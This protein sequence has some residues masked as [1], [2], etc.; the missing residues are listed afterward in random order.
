MTVEVAENLSMVVRYNG[1]TIHF[2]GTEQYSQLSGAMTMFNGNAQTLLHSIS[3]DLNP[4]ISPEVAFAEL[5]YKLD[6]NTDEIAASGNLYK[7][8]SEP[9]VIEQPP[10]PSAWDSWLVGTWQHYSG[11]Q[12][13]IDDDKRLFY[14]DANQVSFEL[15]VE[16]DPDGQSVGGSS[17]SDST[18]YFLDAEVFS[19]I[20]SG[21][22][23]DIIVANVNLNGSMII[24]GGFF[25]RVSE[26]PPEPNPE[27]DW[28]GIWQGS[29]GASIDIDMDTFKMV[30]TAPNTTISYD[31]VTYYDVGDGREGLVTAATEV[32]INGQSEQVTDD[33]MLWPA[34]VDA[35][36]IFVELSLYG[37]SE[38]FIR[39]G[40]EPT[41]GGENAVQFE[42]V[43]IWLRD[44]A[45][46]STAIEPYADVFIVWMQ[47]AAS[48]EVDQSDNLSAIGHIFHTTAF[49]EADFTATEAQVGVYGVGGGQA[50]Y[51]TVSGD[52]MSIETLYVSGDHSDSYAST[53]SR[54]LPDVD[55]STVTV[56]DVIDML[57][58]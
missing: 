32:L 24:D 15:Y 44:G 19:A 14:I 26:Q 41:S 5:D 36:T 23:S 34:P 7:V 2:D 4:T 57:T 8:S 38:N 20:N 10:E 39:T 51:L 49:G 1:D 16:F 50:N 13:V 40:S 21:D 30:F 25:Y 53:W 31:I 22:A 43:G 29:N 6:A 52:S 55:P 27:M 54:V 46:L 33:F 47:P 9:P 12:I 18:E 45:D 28:N 17:I 37:I 58:E 42:G 48:N 11:D 3:F 35:D 56:Q